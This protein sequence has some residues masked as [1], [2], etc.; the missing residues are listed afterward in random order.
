M[1]DAPLSTASGEGAFLT[2]AFVAEGK[3]FTL[4]TFGDSAVQAP[5]HLGAIRVGGQ[6]GFVDREGLATSRYDAA[7]G[8]TYLL[9]PDGYVAAR[10]RRPDRPA[11]DA[12]L[13]RACGLN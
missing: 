9:R 1:A 12:A 2:D 6:G 3:R 8:A 4:L 7:P 11:I 10:F 13:S 5:D